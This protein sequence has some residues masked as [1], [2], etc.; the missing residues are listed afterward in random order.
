MTANEITPDELRIAY[1]QARWRKLGIGFQRA[2][3]SPDLLTA[4]RCHALAIRRSYEKHGIP[5]PT[6]R[7]VHWEG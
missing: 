1:Q 4:L 2:I 6:R 3:E 7:V 5:A